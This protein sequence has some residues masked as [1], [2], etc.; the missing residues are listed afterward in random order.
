MMKNSVLL[1]CCASAV[2]AG[3]AFGEAT[4]LS[5]NTYRIQDAA[6]ASYTVSSVVETG[7]PSGLP[8]PIFWFDCQQTNDW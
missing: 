5:G 4:V 8:T 2:A 3:V 1:A 6:D 7:Y